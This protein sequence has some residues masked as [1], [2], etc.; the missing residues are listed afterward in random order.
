M[1]CD[2]GAYRCIYDI[3]ENQIGW[4]E[5][6]ET[7][8]DYSEKII[9]LKAHALLRSKRQR[10][11]KKR[12]E[13]FPFCFQC[14]CVCMFDESSQSI[15]ETEIWGV[16]GILFLVS[17]SKAPWLSTTNKVNLNASLVNQTGSFLRTSRWPPFNRTNEISL[18]LP[19]FGNFCCSTPQI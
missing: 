7:W 1:K 9:T 3:E 10:E 5:A 13:H 15:S 8:P 12:R 18:C 6:N 14:W 16:L 4:T 17:P 2:C 11:K 19:K